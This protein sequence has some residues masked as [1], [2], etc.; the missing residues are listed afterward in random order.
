MCGVH[1]RLEAEALRSLHNHHNP[2]PLPPFST[3]PLRTGHPH[4]HEAIGEHGGVGGGC[5]EQRAVAT[6]RDDGSH[7]HARRVGSEVQR[8]D[9]RS[10][11]RGDLILILILVLSRAIYTRHR[12]KEI[13]VRFLVGRL[14][15]VDRYTVVWDFIAGHSAGRSAGNSTEHSAGHSTPRPDDR[16]AQHFLDLSGK[17]DP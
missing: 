5:A 8:G 14:S 10:D 1:S 12:S 9:H 15:V 2:P 7:G 16:F 13:L 17:V 3:P 11:L 6:V 4:P